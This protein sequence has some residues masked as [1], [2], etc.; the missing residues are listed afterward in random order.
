MSEEFWSKKGSPEMSWLERRQK[1]PQYDD[2]NK[3]EN[4]QND[5]LLKI[6]SESLWNFTFSCSF[7]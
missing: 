3:Y 7:G 1:P 5:V 2:E 4:S 6:L